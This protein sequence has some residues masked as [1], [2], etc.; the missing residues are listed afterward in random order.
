MS[1]VE[2]REAPI[3]SCRTGP[4]WRSVGGDSAEERPR[5]LRMM[6]PSMTMLVSP[7]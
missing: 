3:V 5:L 2:P 7:R 1:K 4:K 6:F